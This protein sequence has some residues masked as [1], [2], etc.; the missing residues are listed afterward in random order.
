MKGK[1]QRSMSAMLTRF[2]S[3]CD[4][5]HLTPYPL[6]FESLGKFMVNYVEQN[7]GS[8]RS[9]DL[10][11]SYFKRYCRLEG[12]EYLSDTDSYK[13]KLL[14]RQLQFQ[15]V[16]GPNR[17]RPLTL[18]YLLDILPMLNLNKQRDLIGITMLF[19]GH[20]GLLRSGELCNQLRVDDVQ[21]SPDKHSLVLRLERTKT[22]RSGAAEYV[23][24]MDRKGCWSAVKLLRMYFDTF[25]L[26]HSY[27]SV[28]F[29]KVRYNKLSWSDCCQQ[30][31][32]R[33]FIKRCVS[34]I[35]LN[36][37][38]YSGHSLRAGGATDLFV[39]QVPYPYI[40]KFGRWKS[41]TALI[42]YRDEDNLAVV[43][44]DAFLQMNKYWWGEKNKKITK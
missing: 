32:L 17:K 26:W 42:Y 43:A 10:V 7:K 11:L 18:N 33:R 22:N 23:T 8:T 4:V 38:L 35:G 5:N 15:D 40:K 1:S 39:A 28:L 25:N 36:P 2:E 44:A 6:I 31:W 20:D 13:L 16:K 34:L 9:V 12:K 41:D 29:P 27:G 24:F 37:K 14:V 19:M 30:S 3:W 21:W